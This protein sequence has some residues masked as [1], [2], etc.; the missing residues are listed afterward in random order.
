MRP[1][2]SLGLAS[3]LMVVTWVPRT[4]ATFPLTITALGA[5]PLVL[6]AAQVSAIAGVAILAKAGKFVVSDEGSAK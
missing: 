5:A 4:E 3:L 2:L 1:S 6:T